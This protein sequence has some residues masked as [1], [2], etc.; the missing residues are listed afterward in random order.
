MNHFNA[1]DFSEC[2]FEEVMTLSEHACRPIASFLRGGFAYFTGPPLAGTKRPSGWR[3]WEGVL[4]QYLHIKMEWSGAYPRWIACKFADLFFFFF[5]G[6]GPVYTY[7]ITSPGLA[8]IIDAQCYVY[9][10]FLLLVVLFFIVDV[11]NE[12]VL[13]LID[14]IS[15]IPGN[16]FPGI[17]SQLLCS[18]YTC[19]TA[20]Q[21]IF[22]VA[23]FFHRSVQNFI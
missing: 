16:N 6:N 7:T 4:L 2:R 1:L 3:V 12:N 10:L 21:N 22:C 19:M 14:T 15:H 20:I 18:F 13:M 23:V 11:S 8:C 9:D 5:F 17:A